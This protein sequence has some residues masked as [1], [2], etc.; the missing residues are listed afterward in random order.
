MFDGKP[1][2]RFLI[3]LLVEFDFEGIDGVNQW[4]SILNNAESKRK[5]VLYKIDPYGERF[6]NKLCF[7]ATEAIRYIL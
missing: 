5:S 3:Y 7:N 2:L 1:C 6:Q 4:T